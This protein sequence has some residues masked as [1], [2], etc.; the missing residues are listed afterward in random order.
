MRAG[1]FITFEGLEGV[2]KTTALSMLVE[3][4]ERKG[5]ECIKTRE[6]GGTELA[7]KIRELVLAHH[8]ESVSEIT[9]LLLMFAARSQ[10]V[11]ETIRPAIELGQWVI[12]D[13]FTDATLAYQGYG[14]GFSLEPIRTLSELVHP[15]LW[16]DATVLLEASEETTAKRL[17]RRESASDRIE[18]ERNS[19]FRRV[20]NGYTEL[21]AASPERF[22]TVDANEDIDG[23]RR[24]INRIAED[25]IGRWWDL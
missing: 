10:N 12:S 3:A 9:E 13:R 17:K 2:G 6:P 18:A 4:L 16:P 19:F 5:V 7:E 15:D 8:T 11:Q 22:Y 14:R 1:R 24:Q 23:V 21:A 20:A 25:M